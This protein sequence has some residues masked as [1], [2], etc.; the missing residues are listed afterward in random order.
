MLLPQPQAT[1]CE[2][3]TAVLLHASASS[4]RQWEALA[5]ALA[6]RFA[7]QTPPLLGH[8]GAEAP[9]GGEALTLA[10]DAATVQAIA[11][12]CGPLLLV[13]HSYGAAVALKFAA[14]HPQAVAGIAVY[15]PVLLSWLL[16]DPGSR[17]PAAELQGTGQGCRRL[18][19]EGQ[20][21]LAAQRFAD[22]WCGPRS[23]ATMP[24][25]AREA[26]AQRMPV[27]AAQFGALAAEPAA[28]A[29]PRQPAVPTL[30]LGGLASTAAARRIG[31]LLRQRWPDAQHLWLPG[32]GHMGPLTHATCVNGLIEQW[33]LRT[34]GGAA[35]PGTVRPR[36]W[37]RA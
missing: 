9:A 1:S 15:E 30:V 35:G 34:A 11:E 19:A 12:R 7:V 24:L 6:P 21:L 8:G 22:H 16:Q 14:Q 10:H 27:V 31:V 13:G 5:A 18:V 26:M 23:W 29:A 37:A 32:V 36:G 28:S 20:H 33:L 2:R 17:E 4:P 3:P 25:R